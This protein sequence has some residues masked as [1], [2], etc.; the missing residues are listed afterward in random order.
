MNVA[1]I[2]SPGIQ[3]YCQYAVSMS[4]TPEFPPPASLPVHLPHSFLSY[5]PESSHGSW[6]TQSP[7]PQSRLPMPFLFSIKRNFPRS[8]SPAVLVKCSLAAHS[9]VSPS[10]MNNPVNIFNF[11]KKRCACVRFSLRHS[12]ASTHSLRYSPAPAAPVRS[13]YIGKCP[14]PSRLPS[15]TRCTHC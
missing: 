7:A 6:H 11:P 12:R 8:Y 1:N 9:S 15:R 13:P 10:I 3:T 14:P 4:S 5:L 2:S